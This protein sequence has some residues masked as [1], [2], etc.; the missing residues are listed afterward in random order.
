MRVPPFL[1]S[2]KGRPEEAEIDMTLHSLGFVEA[3]RLASRM[4]CLKG[5]LRKLAR[6]DFFLPQILWPKGITSHFPP[7]SQIKHSWWPAS[8]S[9]ENR[10]QA[11]ESRICGASTRHVGMFVKMRMRGP[12]P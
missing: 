8:V 11:T 12:P 2:E 5:K 1:F 10:K 9:I 3:V 7:Q 6:Q 4:A